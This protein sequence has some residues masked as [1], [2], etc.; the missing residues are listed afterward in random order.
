MKIQNKNNKPGRNDPCPCGSGRKYKKC[1]MNNDNDQQV[2]LKEYYYQ[3][4]KI[5]LKTAAEID[6][7]K[8]AGRLVIQTLE[9]IEEHIKPDMTTENIVGSLQEFIESPDKYKATVQKLVSLKESLGSK[10][11][12]IEVVNLIRRIT[13][14]N[15]NV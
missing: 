6:G 1:C 15:E 5:R 13:G 9:M 3:K 2:D 8:K 4:H 11:P 14:I 7:I 12:S 10:K